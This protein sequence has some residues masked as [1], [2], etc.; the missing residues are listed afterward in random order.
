MVQKNMWFYQKH[1]FWFNFTEKKNPVFFKR[2]LEFLFIMMYLDTSDH[3]FG[4]L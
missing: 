2:L 3:F 1:M 4:K